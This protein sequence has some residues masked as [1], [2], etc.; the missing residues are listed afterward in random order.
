MLFKKISYFV[1]RAFSLT[2]NSDT[3][4]PP[5]RFAVAP[6]AIG[7]RVAVL[8]QPRDHGRV[9]GVLIG[10]DT[11]PPAGVLLSDQQMDEALLQTARSKEKRKNKVYLS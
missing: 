1:D 5:T 10:M 11:D 7:N 8:P 3:N 4:L 6:V 2:L 9:L